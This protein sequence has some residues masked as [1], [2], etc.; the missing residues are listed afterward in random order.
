MKQI[1]TVRIFDSERE[2]QWSFVVD[3]VSNTIDGYDDIIITGGIGAMKKNSDMCV[4]I[5]VEELSLS[6]SA[7]SLTNSTIEVSNYLFVQHYPAI[8]GFFMGMPI[9]A[10]G[11]E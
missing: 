10:R 9:V 1:E 4:R 2:F 5:A 7:P 8:G 3:T 6:R 11:E